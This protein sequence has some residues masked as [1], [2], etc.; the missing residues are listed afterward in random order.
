MHHQRHTL[1]A[2]NAKTNQMPE[3]LWSP[4]PIINAGRPKDRS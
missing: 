4:Q 2:A 3:A 1:N